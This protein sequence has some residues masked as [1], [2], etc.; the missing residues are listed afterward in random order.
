[1][2]SQ[3]LL[4]CLS[5]ALLSACAGTPKEFT[6]DFTNADRNGDQK[7]S[8]S[9][10]LT[11]GG[12]EAAFLATD[13]KRSGFLDEGQ[14]RE[15]LRLADKDGSGAQRQQINIDQQLVADVSAAL[16]GSPDLYP[17]SV[18]VLAFQGNV[19]LTGSVR[20]QKEKQV[21]EAIAQRIARSRAVFN[22][23]VIRQ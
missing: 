21:A 18:Q 12:T 19:T 3:R 1:M 20:T 11:F 14:F 13:P 17:G 8:L 7:I 4:A 9:E 23:I 15:A 22:Q 16:A 5:L 6:A 2:T 10:F